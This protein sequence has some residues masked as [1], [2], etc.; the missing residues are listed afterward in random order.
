MFTAL[1]PAGSAGGVSFPFPDV[2]PQRHEIVL[3]SRP[4]GCPVCV[5]VETAF[6]VSGVPFVK[7]DIDAPENAERVK[8]LLANAKARSLPLMFINGENVAAGVSC[9]SEAHSRGY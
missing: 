7:V 5:T 1:Q 4:A 8:V 6:K 2:A 9:I 3:L